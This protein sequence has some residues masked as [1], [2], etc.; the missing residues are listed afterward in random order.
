MK[1]LKDLKKKQ[2]KQQTEKTKTLQEEL[3][4]ISKKAEKKNKKTSFTKIATK[5]D[6]KP[7][8]TSLNL[9]NE[10]L[11]SLLKPLIKKAQK[12]KYIT[13]TE[14]NDFLPKKPK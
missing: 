13:F 11:M 2:E 3:E 10:E 7:V 6:K 4:L 14:I 8:A 1:R 9:T 5:T 12:N